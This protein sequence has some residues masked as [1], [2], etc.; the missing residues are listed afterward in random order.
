VA[1]VCELF[2]RILELLALRCRR[3]RPNDIEILDL[4]K[5]LVVLRRQL[6]RP[7]FDERDRIVLAALS[8]VLPRN[9][10]NAFCATRDGPALA[11]PNCCPTLDLPAPSTWT[12]TDRCRSAPACAAPRNR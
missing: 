5:Q 6:S 3:D 10:W 11:S 9:R 1:V 2:S 4:R 8:R 7:R 12:T